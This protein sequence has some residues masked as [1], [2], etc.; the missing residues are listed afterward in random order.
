MGRNLLE[1]VRE[2]THP[3]FDMKK[4]ILL[5]VA[6]LLPVLPAAAEVKLS[7]TLTR[8]AGH[9]GD[10]GVH[11]SVTDLKDDLKNLGQLIDKVIEAVPEADIPPGLN[12]ETLFE[13]LGF[14]AV[15]GRG[16]LGKAVALLMLPG[17]CLA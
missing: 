17:I 6:A 11:F 9:L 13:E 7:G 14:Y 12:V 2:I 8:I 15:Q 3:S 16:S 5:C 1:V 10:G 4:F